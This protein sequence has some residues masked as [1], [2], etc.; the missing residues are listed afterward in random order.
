MTRR[1]AVYIAALLSAIALQFVATPSAQAQ[2]GSCRTCPSLMV[3]G[4][5]PTFTPTIFKGANA[6]FDTERSGE[7]W[8][9]SELIGRPDQGNIGLG[10]TYTYETN[11]APT[12]LLI[13]GSW[14]RETDV[15][16]LLD[17]TPIAVLN[18]PA[19]DGQGGACPTC[20]WTNPSIAQRRYQNAQV[21]FHRADLATVRLDGQVALS[22]EAKLIPA[23]MALVRG[24]PDYFVGRW[25]FT[26]RS[27]ALNGTQIV[28]RNYETHRCETQ[29]AR[30]SSPTAENR[31][32]PDP[33]GAPYYMP[34]SE[35]A[36]EWVSLDVEFECPEG[37]A[38]DQLWRIAY[39]PGQV[40]PIRG[41]ALQSLLPVNGQSQGPIPQPVVL[42]YTVPRTSRWIELY[43]QDANTMIIRRFVNN[44]PNDIRLGG[45]YLM[46]RVP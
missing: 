2:T 36:A 21:T 12:W 23:E 19:F 16:A 41:V 4:R 10:V 32:D 35:A 22:G 20:P 5:I 30:A 42:R 9:F 8:A 28:E 15:R 39:V 3:N 44:N 13:Q 6:W 26:L 46:T 38:S 25:R 45:E 40:G 27:N 1:T 11:G 37:S 17:G 14:T 24:L 34:P 29:I 31:F 43:L 7:G 33:A 18:G